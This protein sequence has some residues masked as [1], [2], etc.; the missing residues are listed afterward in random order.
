MLMKWKRWVSGAK[1]G[2]HGMRAPVGWH[3]SDRNVAGKKVV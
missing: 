2:D 1:C 3:V